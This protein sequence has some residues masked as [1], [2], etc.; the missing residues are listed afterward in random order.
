MLVLATQPRDFTVQEEEEILDNEYKFLKRTDDNFPAE[1][2]RVS[3]RKSVIKYLN[4]EQSDKKDEKDDG[5][6]KK[7]A[8]NVEQRLKNTEIKND[9]C[10][11]T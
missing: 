1:E 6:K 4:G 11:K 5:N 8:P 3:V 9:F 7:K 2:D 10:V